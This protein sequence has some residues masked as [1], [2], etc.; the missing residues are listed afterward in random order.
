MLPRLVP[1]GPHGRPNVPAMTNAPS[2]LCA[3]KS[4]DPEEPDARGAISA[5]VY[6]LV[7]GLGM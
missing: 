5:L 3:F 2:G 6:L 1:S 7:L 4:I